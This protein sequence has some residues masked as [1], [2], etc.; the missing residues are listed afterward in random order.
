MLCL[1][2]EVEILDI[3]GMLGCFLE[4][5][6]GGFLIGCVIVDEVE[7]LIIVVDFLMWC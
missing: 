5:V 7:F 4:W 1:W 6:V 2:S 3:L